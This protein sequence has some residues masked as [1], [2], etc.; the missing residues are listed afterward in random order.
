MQGEEESPRARGSKPSAATEAA[1][2]DANMDDGRGTTDKQ[3]KESEE[4]TGK[5]TKRPAEEEAE[6]VTTSLLVA[7]NAKRQR[8]DADWGKVAPTTPPC[9]SPPPFPPSKWA[10]C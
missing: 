5:G 9:A 2:A 8:T 3:L 6:R 1:P 7:P 4:G 10:I